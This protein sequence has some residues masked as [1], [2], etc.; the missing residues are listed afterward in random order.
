MTP[1]QWAA[2]LS[3]ALARYDKSISAGDFDMRFYL[4]CLMVELEALSD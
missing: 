4:C 1:L 2:V 3:K